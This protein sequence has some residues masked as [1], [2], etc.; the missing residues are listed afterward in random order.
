MRRLCRKEAIGGERRQKKAKPLERW[1]D[2]WKTELKDRSLS[3]MIHKKNVRSQK[4]DPV[5]TEK[6]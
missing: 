6:D 1:I 5:S 4:S 2:E 3:E